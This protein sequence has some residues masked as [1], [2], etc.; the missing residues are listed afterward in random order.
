M[1]SGKSICRD[2]FFALHRKLFFFMCAIVQ[3][4]HAC[5]C[6][7]PIC[8]QRNVRTSLKH[9]VP[10]ITSPFCPSV[11]PSLITKH[12]L[13]RVYSPLFEF[14]SFSLP[15][16]WTIPSKWP[17]PESSNNHGRGRAR[18]KDALFCSRQMI[19]ITPMSTLPQPDLRTRPITDD[20]IIEDSSFD[21]NEKGAKQMAAKEDRESGQGGHLT[22]DAQLTGAEHTYHSFGKDEQIASHVRNLS[23]PF[24]DATMIKDTASPI[25]TVQGVSFDDRSH[26]GLTESFPVQQLARE[27]KDF[28]TPATFVPPV[29][30]ASN[31]GQ[32]H[33]RGFSDDFSNPPH[34][35]RRINSIGNVAPVERGPAY[36]GSYPN[37]PRQDPPTY[38]PP[39]TAH[40][41]KASEGLDMLSAAVSAD[42]SKEEFAAA[43]V[44]PS[45]L[46]KQPDMEPPSDATRPAHHSPHEAVMMRTS[47]GT[48]IAGTTYDYT[49]AVA[50]NMGAP[51]FRPPHSSQGGYHPS[52]QPYHYPPQHGYHIS[53]SFYP[54]YSYYPSGA[55][56]H[57]GAPPQVYNQRQSPTMAYPMHYPT[58]RGPDSYAKG[59]FYRSH[60]PIAPATSDSVIH[61][62][63][64][65]TGTMDTDEQLFENG[66]STAYQP[67]PAQ[68]GGP[69][70]PG[71]TTGSQT[72]VT[73]IS[74]GEG[75]RT[76][77]PKPR[78][79]S[80]STNTDRSSNDQQPP[81]PTTVGH[82]R[83]HSSFSSLSTLMNV[84]LFQGDLVPQDPSSEKHYRSMSSNMSFLPGLDDKT[85]T[86]HGGHH[87]STSSVSF[88]HGLDDGFDPHET[89]TQ[90]MEGSGQPYH[91]SN[92]NS[93]PVGSAQKAHHYGAS[94]GGGHPRF[95]ENIWASAPISGDNDQACSDLASGRTSKRVRSA[96]NARHY[97]ASDGGGQPRSR[98]KALAS[99]RSIGDNDQGS[100]GLASGGTSK[101]LRR[102]CAVL[103]CPNRVVQGGH[104]I[105]HG[106]KRKTCKHPGCTKNV[107]KAGMCSTHGP[108]RKRCEVAGCAKVS[109]Q[110]GLCIAHGAK[111]KLCQVEGCK[112]QAILSGMCKKHRD[113]NY[114]TVSSSQLDSASEKTAPLDMGTSVEEAKPEPMPTMPTHIRGLSIFQEEN[115][116][117]FLFSQPLDPKVK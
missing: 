44:A 106:A 57:G 15:I 39:L 67:P 53:P 37:P 114:G 32:K 4:V 104:C 89:F 34:A 78:K 33:S 12:C 25:Q 95:R 38:P 99:V 22:E 23:A 14:E 30:P 59:Q 85:M 88:L 13:H 43:A 71:T 93:S 94:Y 97:G 42:I 11:S 77:Y 28:S 45:P 17:H 98:G 6:M 18:Q 35:H 24:F 62:R 3:S 73:A 50:G 108:A 75:N 41:R 61:N 72:L 9:D 101:R 54:H 103:N 86:G 2:C 66:N 8:G 69:P 63:A 79:K 49:Q 70:C 102:K 1:T 46:V 31:V 26:R 80:V 109:V 113:Q 112:K 55:P 20:L 96:Q 52:S 5:V 40:H 111:K 116:Q 47:P 51:P 21:A 58:Q 110:G 81:I 64:E 29:S 107:K 90:S 76:I 65:S 84:H 105:A 19:T 83:K 68:W 60:Q 92:V 117:T 27:V 36:Y 91:V 16:S 56:P 115:I 100:S 48:V 10:T 7:V 87:R 74:V 82:H